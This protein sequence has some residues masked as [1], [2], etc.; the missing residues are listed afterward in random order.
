MRA[1]AVVGRVGGL[2][3]AL[4]IG[5]AVGISGAGGALAAPADISPSAEDTAPTRA[6]ADTAQRARQHRTPSQDSCAAGS[7]RSSRTI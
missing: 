3:V 4:G 7:R 1:A 6:H 5:V 2:A